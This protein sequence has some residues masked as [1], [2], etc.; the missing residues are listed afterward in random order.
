MD[1]EFVVS[2]SVFGAPLMSHF[3]QCYF[4]RSSDICVGFYLTVLSNKSLGLALYLHPREGLVPC[5]FPSFIN[6][7][8]WVIGPGQPW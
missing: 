3:P 6:R 7:N 5:S 1:F 4:V 2:M 8:S